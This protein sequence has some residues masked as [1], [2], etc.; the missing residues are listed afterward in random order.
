MFKKGNSWY[1]DFVYR[2][3]RCIESQG[4]QASRLL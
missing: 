3:R 2:G 4:R 1:S